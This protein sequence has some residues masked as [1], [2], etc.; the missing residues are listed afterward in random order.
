MKASSL[1]SCYISPDISIEQFIPEHFFL[2][3]AKGAMTAYDGHQEYKIEAGEYGLARRNA[4]AKYSKQPVNGQFEKVI[5]VFDQPFLRSFQEQHAYAT[6][7]VKSN[8]AIFKLAKSP[9]VEHFLQSLEPHFNPQGKMDAAFLDIKR[10]EL[11]LILL[12]LKPDLAN[13]LFDFGSPEKIDLEAFMY[14]NYKFNVS[15]ERFAYLTGRSLSAFKRDFKQIFNSTPSH[16]LVQKRL[17]EAHFLMH[18]KGQKPSDV[19]LELGFEDLSHFSF[20]FKKLFG[21]TPTQI[22]DQGK[23]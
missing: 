10:T 2:Y 19:Y 5:M 1:S 14:K 15:I 20:A 6:H 16:W 18:K 17:Q 11:L 21:Q 8:D 4:L 9:T 23:V 12:N 3:L 7:Q 13:V 22:L